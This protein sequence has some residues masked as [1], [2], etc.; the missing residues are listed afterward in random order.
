MRKS[1]I[2]RAIALAATGALAL[3]TAPAAAY[4]ARAAR[5]N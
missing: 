3:T 2:P 5:R 4:A 1:L